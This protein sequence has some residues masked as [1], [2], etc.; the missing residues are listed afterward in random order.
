MAYASLLKSEFRDQH[1]ALISR[2]RFSLLAVVLVLIPA[3][4]SAQPE[5]PASRIERLLNPLPN[6]NVQVSACVMSLADGKIIYEKNPDSPMIPASNQKIITAA[7]ALDI[8]GTDFVFETELYHADNDLVIV[9]SGDPGFGDPNLAKNQGRTPLAIFQDWASI[10][11]QRGIDRIDGNIVVDDTV[12]DEER[13]HPSWKG[14]DLSKWYAAPV[15]GL[16]FNDNCVEF[17]VQPTQPGRPVEVTFFPPNNWLRIINTCKTGTKNKPGVNRPS[18]TPEFRIS[19]ECRERTELQSVAIPDPTI[20]TGEVFKKVLQDQGILVRG[21]VRK[22]TLPRSL[23]SND[24]TGAAI[25]QKLTT[26]RTSI[27]D[28]LRRTLQNSQNLFAECLFKKVGKTITGPAENPAPLSNWQAGQ[29]AVRQRL[30]SWGVNT[31]GMVIADGSG[32]SRDNRVSSR[33]IVEI[34][35]HLYLDSQK[36]PVFMESLSVNGSKGTLEKRLKDFPGRVWGKTGYING[37]RSLSGYVR[38]SE[39]RWYVFSVLF[40]DIPGGT[41]PYNQIHDEICRILIQS[42]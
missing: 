24:A 14:E 18:N 27:A 28:V 17:T 36:G 38:A 1:S 2:L 29:Q 39:N 10:L 12:F 4:V 16:N 22:G 7:V 30:E 41:A 40:N 31:T 20:F 8:L 35:R 33:Q 26:A 23:E 13:F 15:G 11:K 42:P 37:V 21:E 5:E 6:K 32:L 9:G 25:P 34:L 3:S 19:G